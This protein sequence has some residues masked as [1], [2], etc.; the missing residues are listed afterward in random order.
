MYLHILYGA[1]FPRIKIAVWFCVKGIKVRISFP[2]LLVLSFENNSSSS[3]E[4]VVILKSCSKLCISSDYVLF[5]PASF[6]FYPSCAKTVGRRCSD[7]NPNIRVSQRRMFLIGLSRLLSYF[8]REFCH[9]A[10]HIKCSVVR[11]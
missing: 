1:L 2:E 11:N 8:S 9:L 6:A 7:W 5:I 10:H 3:Y 4:D